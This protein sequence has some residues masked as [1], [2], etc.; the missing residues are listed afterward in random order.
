MYF[1]S[2]NYFV[3]YTIIVFELAFNSNLVFYVKKIHCT[4]AGQGTFND[5]EL[6]VSPS[7]MH[8]DFSYI[9]NVPV[10]SSTSDENVFDHIYYQLLVIRVMKFI[11]RIAILISICFIFI[12]LGLVL[13]AP[14][15]ENGLKLSMIIIG[16]FLIFISIFFVF[17]VKV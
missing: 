4:H 14:G 5:I 12:S 1:Y 9:T 2:L 7:F 10:D 13:A 6:S 16:V 17:K 11:A 3:L 8:A 15:V